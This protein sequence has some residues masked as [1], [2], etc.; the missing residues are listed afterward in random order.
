VCLR[1]GRGRRRRGAF[2]VGIANNEDAPLLA[3]AEVGVLVASD[4]EVIAGSSR[5]AA[6][7]AQKAVL[8]T[9]STALMPEIG[10][11]YRNLVVGMTLVNRK[12]HRSGA[13]SGRVRVA[14]A[15][16]RG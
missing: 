4:P 9:I 3:E 11:I 15:V 16:L 7:T 2:I 1:G 5:M 14:I 8:N 12:L 13:G 6:G 10:G